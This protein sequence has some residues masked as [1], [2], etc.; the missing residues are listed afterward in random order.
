MRRNFQIMLVPIYTTS[1]ALWAAIRAVDWL[2]YS[3]I[4]LATYLCLTP[5][6]LYLKFSE[7]IPVLVSMLP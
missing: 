1:G 5:L 3:S 2:V 6:T 4:L 7:F